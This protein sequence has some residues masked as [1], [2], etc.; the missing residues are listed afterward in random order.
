MI[1]R[2]ES[3]YP[4]MFTPGTTAIRAKE[5]RVLFNANDT[6][7]IASPT[8]PAISQLRFPVPLGTGGVSFFPFTHLALGG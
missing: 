2:I 1:G 6:Q 3:C 4:W 8:D 5:F 7:A